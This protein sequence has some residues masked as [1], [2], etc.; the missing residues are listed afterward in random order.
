V[1]DESGPLPGVSILIKGTTSGAETDFDG[2]YAIQA[3][4]GDVL[5]FSFIGMSPQE[6]VVGIAN[7]I[8]VVLVADNILE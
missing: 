2:N 1:T 8:N 5:V 6:K 4:T 7:T 3:N